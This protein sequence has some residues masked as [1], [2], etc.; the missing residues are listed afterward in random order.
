[1][2]VLLR[3]S[4]TP[5]HLPTRRSGFEPDIIYIMCIWGATLMGWPYIASTGQTNITL[6]F[7][8]LCVFYP[9]HESQTQSIIKAMFS[10][11]G[12]STWHNKAYLVYNASLSLSLSH[13]S[14]LYH[15]WLKSPRPLRLWE[16]QLPPQQ[17]Q[18][19]GVWTTLPPQQLTRRAAG[20]H[21]SHLL[22]F[23]RLLPLQP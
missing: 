23:H 15:H 20:E 10:P 7:L 2:L 16:P 3:F 14:Q 12:S 19:T 6:C 1:M 18:R 17:P 22:W 11:L 8:C 9:Q 21:P 5:G 13:S 4:G